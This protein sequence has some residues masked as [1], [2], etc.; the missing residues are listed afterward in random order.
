MKINIFCKNRRAYDKIERLI[1]PLTEFNIFDKCDES[2]AKRAL[3]AFFTEYMKMKPCKYVMPKNSLCS[4]NSYYS[5]YRNLIPVMCA[6][7]NN[8]Y[9]K[10]CNEIVTL[11]HNEF[12]LQK[13][14]YIAMRLLY[15][16][17][18]E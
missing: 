13:R 5:F 1:T 15:Q 12:I 3:I 18:L 11:E 2:E 16:K 14:I 17:Y 7:Q 6:L 10:A 8:E 9:A 4:K